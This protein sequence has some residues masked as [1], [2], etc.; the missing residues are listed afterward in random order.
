[1]RPSRRR[2][3]RVRPRARSPRRGTLREC[4]SQRK[5]SPTARR[6]LRANCGRARHAQKS[7]EPLDIPS[8]RS[9][10]SCSFSNFSRLCGRRAGGDEVEPHEGV[11]GGARGSGRS[12]DSR[13]LALARDVLELGEQAQVHGGAPAL[14]PRSTASSRTERR[15]LSA[16][17]SLGATEPRRAPAAA[18]AVTDAARTKSP[19]GPRGSRPRIAALMAHRFVCSGVARLPPLALRAPAAAA[20]ASGRRDARRAPR[21][22][23]K[24]RVRG[25][26]A[27]Q[28]PRSRTGTP[29]TTGTCGT[30]R[31]QRRGSPRERR[32][33]GSS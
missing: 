2:R 13:S 24:R 33:P 1:M 25:R 19:L 21:G 27:A 28:A 15:G 30:L 5:R 32:P 20:T 9:K 4:R 22:S 11:R 6:P 23:V 7:S 18:R 12:R 26:P 8:D 16:L 17:A 14:L 29:P 3:R 31:A 10:V